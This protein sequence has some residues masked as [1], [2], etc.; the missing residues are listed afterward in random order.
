MSCSKWRWTEICDYRPGPGDCDLCDYEEEDDEDI[1]DPSGN[2]CGVLPD[3]TRGHS[4]TYLVDK[5]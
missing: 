4:G 3:N 5:T 2:G 1:Y